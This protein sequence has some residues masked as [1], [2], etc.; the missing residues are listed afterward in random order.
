M[1]HELGI[2][3]KTLIGIEKGRSSLGWTGSAA[4][5]LLFGDSPTLRRELSGDPLRT[6]AELRGHT[7]P[8]PPAPT[9]AKGENN[10]AFPAPAPDGAPAAEVPPASSPLW[11]TVARLGRFTAEQ[12]MISEHYRLLDPSGR[13]VF[14]SFDYPEVAAE[15]AR[16]T[17]AGIQD[18]E[19]GDSYDAKQKQ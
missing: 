15:A 5:C 11:R 6:A 13:R 12:N 9:P 17:E 19:G 14:A 18:T 2:S 3:K 10:L 16:L 7:P 1:A 8:E 4:L